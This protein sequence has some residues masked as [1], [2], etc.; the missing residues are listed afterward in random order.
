MSYFVNVTAGFQTKTE[1]QAGYIANFFKEAASLMECETSSFSRGPITTDK[2]A[3]T[4]TT[5]TVV[6]D[7]H[8]ANWSA[9]ADINRLFLRGIQQ[10]FQNVLLVRKHVFLNDVL[11]AI[12]H[13]PTRD[14]QLVGWYNEPGS[15]PIIFETEVTDNAVL[16]SFDVDGIIY[17]RI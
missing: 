16:I 3:V 1:E 2:I 10:H 17:N 6:F 8:N 13:R 9:H 4:T 14:G 11:A 7:E 5:H 12:G 15:K